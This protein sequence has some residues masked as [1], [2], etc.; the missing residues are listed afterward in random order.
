MGTA[1]AA[2]SCGIQPWPSPATTRPPLSWSR[3]ANRL[4][5]TTAGCSRASMMLVPSLTRSV[6]AAT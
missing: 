5:S 6:S 1:A 4:A 3:V 2:N